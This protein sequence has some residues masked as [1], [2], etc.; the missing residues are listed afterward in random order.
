MISLIEIIRKIVLLCYYRI[1]LTS[2]IIS[3]IIA[4][5]TSENS[6]AIKLAKIAHDTPFVIK[7]NLLN[8]EEFD[9]NLVFLFISDTYVKNFIHLWKENWP[10]TND[11]IKPRIFDV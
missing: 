4:R 10:W 8:Y 7:V 11:P 1:K 6:L 9:K 2:A 5:K 3:G